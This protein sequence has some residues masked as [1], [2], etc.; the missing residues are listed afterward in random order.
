MIALEIKCSVRCLCELANSRMNTRRGESVDFTIS[1][2]RM[3]SRGSFGT[4]TC[5]LATKSC[6]MAVG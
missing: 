2:W 5:M 6:Q 1:G 4:C 3:I